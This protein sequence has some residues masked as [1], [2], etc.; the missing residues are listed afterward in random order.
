MPARKKPIATRTVTSKYIDVP[1]FPGSFMQPQ[2]LYGAF[3]VVETTYGDEVIPFDVLGLVSNP[4]DFKSYIEGR[5]KDH[6]LEVGYGARMSASGYM[7]AT[8]WELFK[9]KAEAIK[10]LKSMYRDMD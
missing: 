6:E 1:R 2:V 3:Y 5:Y 10:Y 4:S 7:D 8:P 9:S